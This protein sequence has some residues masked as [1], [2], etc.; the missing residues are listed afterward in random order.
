MK[1]EDWNK[2][3]LEEFFERKEGKSVAGFI[4]LDKSEYECLI[5][6][7]GRTWTIEREGC[8]IP[9]GGMSYEYPNE[10]YEVEYRRFVKVTYEWVR[11]E[12]PRGTRPKNILHNKGEG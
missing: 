8:E 7:D 12:N 9:Y 3:D 4:I 6:K 5:T 1:D 10:V 2:L 11:I